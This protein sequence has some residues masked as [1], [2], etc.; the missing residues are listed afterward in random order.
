MKGKYVTCFRRMTYRES[1]KFFCRNGNG[2]VNLKI[3]ENT[4]QMG[5]KE[6]SYTC[7]SVSEKTKMACVLNMLVKKGSKNYKMFIPPE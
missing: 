5:F 4:F 3:L 7:V 1:N 6:I 2:M